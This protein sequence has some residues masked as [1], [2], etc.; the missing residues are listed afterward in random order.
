MVDKI[1]ADHQ[2]G[3]IGFAMRIPV[4]PHVHQQRNKR[5]EV[6]ML[7][8]HSRSSVSSADDTWIDVSDHIQ[9]VPKMSYANMP[10][11]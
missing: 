5:K 7:E 4:T 10:K 11:E 6:A 3:W 1:S 2:L 8:T 9:V